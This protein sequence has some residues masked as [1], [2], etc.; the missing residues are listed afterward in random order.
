MATL[1]ADSCLFIHCGVKNVAQ[2][3]IRHKKIKVKLGLLP[4]TDNIP[5]QDLDLTKETEV[6]LCLIYCLVA[7]L[8]S[9]PFQGPIL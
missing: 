9:L 6:L 4:L 5:S 2:K 3:L 7:K 1:L 8:R